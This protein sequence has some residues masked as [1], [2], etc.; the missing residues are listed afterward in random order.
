[1]VILLNYLPWIVLFGAFGLAFY[2]SKNGKTFAQCAGVF[3]AGAL[4]FVLLQALTPSYLPKADVQRVANPTF[5]K[6]DA[7]IEDRLRSAG[8][9]DE[10]QDKFDEKF[11]AVRQAKE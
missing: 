6:S 7:E 11:N 9:E 1:M 5:E 3:V 4:G 8:D 2:W 10:R